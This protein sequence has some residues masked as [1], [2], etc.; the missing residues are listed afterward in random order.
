M[1]FKMASWNVSSEVKEGSLVGSA[2]GAVVTIKV[3]T[4]AGVCARICR[5]NKRHE[6]DTRARSAIVP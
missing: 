3:V 5:V 4:T 2:A 6:A 1:L